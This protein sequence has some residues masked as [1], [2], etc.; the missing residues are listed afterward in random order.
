MKGNLHQTGS[1]SIKHAPVARMP[2]GARPSRA[3]EKR[4]FKRIP[5]MLLLAEDPLSHPAV[6][7]ASQEEVTGFVHS[8]LHAITTDFVP[9]GSD[10][11]RTRR[12]LADASI[13][14]QAMSLTLPQSAEAVHRRN[15]S[16]R[17]DQLLSIINDA[18]LALQ[19]T[20]DLLR[21]TDLAAF[22]EIPDGYA[23][24]GHVINNAVPLLK[25]IEDTVGA[26]LVVLRE[27]AMERYRVATGMEGTA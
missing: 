13:A 2:E 4:A 17:I 6:S 12:L 22:A 19:A 26:D 7:F 18:E 16:V 15:D 21:K 10:Y 5:R 11:Q 9:N 23:F 14:R 25:T 24:R 8:V 20:V 27:E 3:A 1:K